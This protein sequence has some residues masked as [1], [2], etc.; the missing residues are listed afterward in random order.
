MKKCKS[1]IPF[2]ATAGIMLLFYLPMLIVAVDSFNPGRYSGGGWS[3]FSMRWYVKLAQDEDVI[4]AL[5]NS[6]IIGFSATAAAVILGTLAAFAIHL[7]ADKLQKAHR[8]MLIT[9]LGIPDILMGISLL[10]FFISLKMEL[11][12]F[13]IFLAHVTF[14]TSFVAMTVLARL[15][16]FD[17]STVE[18]ARD[19]G[20]GWAIIIRRVIIPQ[21]AP[22]IIA[23]ALLAFTI[24]IDDFVIT[25]FVYGPGSTT[26]SVYIYSMMKH[27]TPVIIN[28]LS[29]VLIIVTF[30]M[31]YAINKLMSRKNENLI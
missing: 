1:K 27:G 18:A 8:L 11:G 14:C 3:G 23:G 25:Y 5:I 12:L 28:A 16:D 7:Y 24:S 26:L 13:T 4:S 29:V 15:Q 20:A 19:L 6:L 31:A 2:F 9:Q 17:F 21:I 22:G 30:I 10:L